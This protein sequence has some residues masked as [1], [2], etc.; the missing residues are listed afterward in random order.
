MRRI[1][2]SPLCAALLGLTAVAYLPVWR[3]D[4]NFIAPPQ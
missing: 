3:N 4:F 1:G 2:T